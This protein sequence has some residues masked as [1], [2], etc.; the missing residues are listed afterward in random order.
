MTS[1][2]RWP[3]VL[4]LLVPLVLLGRKVPQLRAELQDTPKIADKPACIVCH[5]GS[6]SSLRRSPHSILIERQGVDASCLE[7]HATGLAHQAHPKSSQHPAGL[8]RASCA[9]CHSG[10]VA[11]EARARLLSHPSKA[12]ARTAIELRHVTP[13]SEA[14]LP[15]PAGDVPAVGFEGLVRAGWRFVDVAGDERAFDHDFGLDAGPRLARIRLRADRGGSTVVEGSAYGLEDREFTARAATG[16]GLLDWAGAGGSF[17][18]NVYVYDAEGDFHSLSNSREWTEAFLRLD[19]PG[20]DTRIRFSY[21]R[22]DLDGRTLNSSIGNPNQSPLVPATGVPVDRTLASDV[23]RLGW[24]DRASFGS[25]SLEVGWE[26]ARTRGDLAYSRASPVNPGFTE[27]EVR[28]S[29]FSE[30][31][32]EGSAALVVGEE[33]GFLGQLRVAAAQRNVRV[34]ETG[35]L[36][37]FDT[38]AFTSDTLG[39]GSGDRRT[40]AVIAQATQAVWQGAKLDLEVEFVDLKD[41]LQMTQYDTTTRTNPPLVI[42]TQTDLDLLTR[43]QDRGARLALEQSFDGGLDF[44]LGWRYLEQELQVPDLESLDADFRAGTVRFHGPDLSGAWRPDAA[45]T[46]RLDW[47]YA[48]TDSRTPTETQPEIGQRVRA[49]VRRRLDGVDGHVEVFANFRDAENDVSST[50]LTYESYGASLTLPPWRDARFTGRAAW[51]SIESRT[52]T[53]FY[54]GSTT[55]VPTMVDF[56]GDTVLVDL[57]LDTPVCGGLHSMSFFSIQSTNGSLDSTL[58]RFDEELAYRV[59]DSVSVGVQASFFDF[60]E[61]R[62]G[63]EDDYDARV[64]FLFLELRF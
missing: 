17:R 1:C 35:L 12:Q 51:T 52:L 38:S 6:L 21:E 19:D 22:L 24:E 30:R 25:W 44:A 58:L 32:P 62:A 15:R 57:E 46:L 41:D 18:R 55:P 14:E 60:D 5:P 7:C 31:G 34:V 39:V 43:V 47:Q 63:P 26:E 3:A 64:A 20:G 2:K 48:V 36:T 23:F 8:G 37:A 42:R 9:R 29:R 33:D 59:S 53:N 56:R 4:A 40:M 50:E 61:E 27:S 49:R 11:D 13:P 45:W 16:A 28:S 10:M 54:F